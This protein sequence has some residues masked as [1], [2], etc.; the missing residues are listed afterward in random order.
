MFREL[1]VGVVEARLPK[2]NS[3]AMYDP[4]MSCHIPSVGA[5]TPFHI[6]V[7]DMLAFEAHQNSQRRPN[8]AHHKVTISSQNRDEMGQAQIELQEANMAPTSDWS[9]K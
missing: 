7:E 2:P 3:K 8:G 6:I 1:V 5:Q 4:C 9:T